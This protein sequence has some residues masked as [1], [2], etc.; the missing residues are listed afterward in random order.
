MIAFESLPLELRDLIGR[1]PQKVLRELLRQDLNAFVGK[2]FNTLNPSTRYL[3]NWHIEAIAWHLEQVRLGHIK[4]LIIS[5]PPRSAK[6]ISASVAFPAFVHGHDPTKEIVV[7]SYGQSLAA[8]LHNDYRTILTSPWYR[9]VFP[10]T[11]IDPRK[12]TE[13]E[14]RL[15]ARGSRFAT[16]IGGVITGRGADLMIIDDPL[17]PEEAISPQ[18][19]TRVN[20]YFGTT[21]V[22]RLNQKRDGAIVIVSQRLHVDDLVG[23]VTQFDHGWT[24]LNLPAIAY[25]DQDIP[26][27]AGRVFRRKTGS[28]L[29]PE[30]E[31]QDVLDELKFSIGAE[32]FEA[33]YQ[34]RPVP[35]SGNMFKRDWLHYYD[36]LPERTEEGVLFQSWDTASKIQIENDWSVGMTWL[37]EDGQYYLVDVIR[38]KLNYPQLRL[39]M[40][41]SAEVWDPELILV[42]DTGAGTGLISEL[43]QQ[44]LNAVGIVP[45][46]SKEI[47]ANFQTP[48]FQAG[49]VR[50]PRQAPWLAELEAELLAF[51]SGRHDDQVDALVQA[52]GYDNLPI[53]GGVFWI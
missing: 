10:G 45:K 34:Q 44:G 38:V 9:G 19:R 3:P 2:C 30:R 8:K 14:V 27:G 42:E 23:H 43:V 50:F 15:K 1:E 31:D 39:K 28:L 7:V 25:E 35:P 6:S 41:E 20:D 40:L 32:A 16:S 24:V 26:L 36:V 37:Y 4:R 29:H 51:P 22:S 48:A 47:R 13:Q 52:L 53:G 18:L 5:M 17:K 49:R 46:Q 12:D 21:L 33:Q 11:L